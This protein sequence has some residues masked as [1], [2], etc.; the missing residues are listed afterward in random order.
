[1]RKL[2]SR[3]IE[4]TLRRKE[5]IMDIPAIRNRLLSF[6]FRRRKDPFVDLLESAPLTTEPVTED[7]LR[8]LEEGREDYRAGRTISAE[9]IKRQYR[10]RLSKR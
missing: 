6:S 4:A 2:T 1:M 10:E 8:S 5:K 7:D 9:E 3:A